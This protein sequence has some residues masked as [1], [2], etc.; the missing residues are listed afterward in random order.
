V[1]EAAARRRR[2]LFEGA[3]G[4][5]L[6]VDHGTYPFVTSSSATSGGACTGAGLG[7]TSIDAV[8]G[9]TKAYT[10]R[11]G[12][13][14]FPTE[15]LT[16]LGERLRA[17]GGE[18]GATTG[19]PRRCGWL[20]AVVLRHAVRVNGLTS[21]AVTKLDV[22]SGIEDLR[23]CTGYRVG[24]EVLD[25][26]PARRGALDEVEPVYES[27]PGWSED[28]T[29]AVR[30]DQLPS[31]AQAYVRRVQQLVSVPVSLVSVGPG[32]D[33]TIELSDPAPARRARY[34]AVHEV[35]E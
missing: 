30:W 28:I 29:H 22:L 25:E 23:I 27:L 18:F 15:L 9:I 17:K 16:E 10:T 11:V 26:I 4:T 6:D 3:Q 31:A 14:P 35:L 13:G 24:G 7:P 12:A 8:L 2:I 1:H 32:R 20:D 33:Q 19:R 21:L 5:L 34:R